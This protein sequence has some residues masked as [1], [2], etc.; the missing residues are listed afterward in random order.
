MW[1]VFVANITNTLIG[2]Y[3]HGDPMVSALN[4][5]QVRAPAGDIVLCS[6]EGHF[7]LKVPLSTQV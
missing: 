3:R 4:L 1:L 5:V 2:W 7:A 6:W